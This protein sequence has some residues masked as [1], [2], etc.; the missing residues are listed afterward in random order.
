MPSISK[1]E[2]ETLGPPDNLERR[3]NSASSQK[4]QH[5]DNSKKR[6]VVHPLGLNQFKPGFEPGKL[7]KILSSKLIPFPERVNNLW[8][9]SW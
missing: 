6:I 2:V 8:I 3:N 4:Q 7:K 9:P 1:H 5:V